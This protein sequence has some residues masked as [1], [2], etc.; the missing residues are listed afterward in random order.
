MRAF[1]GSLAIDVFCTLVLLDMYLEGGFYFMDE[2]TLERV[3]FLFVLRSVMAKLR[4][5][6]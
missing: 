5:H 3:L 2:R 4:D 1:G 6:S